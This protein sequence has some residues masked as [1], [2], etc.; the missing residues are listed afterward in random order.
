MTELGRPLDDLAVAF[1]GRS[2]PTEPRNY[3]IAYAVD[4][5]SGADL[6]AA[7]IS[8]PKIDAGQDGMPQTIDGR[9]VRVSFEPGRY[10]IIMVAEDAYF[11]IRSPYDQASALDMLAKTD[12]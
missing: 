10:T 1:A 8:D 6:L 7:I 5:V 12:R 9:A 3:A 11:L 4:G 2:S